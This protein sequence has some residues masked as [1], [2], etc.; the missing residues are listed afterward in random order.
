M[1]ETFRE[2]VSASA[3]HGTYTDL[4]V[5][6]DRAVRAVADV[7]HTEAPDVTIGVSWGTRI[8]EMRDTAELVPTL[9]EASGT[10]QRIRLS[11]RN[12][13]AGAAVTLT[14]TPTTPVIEGVVYGPSRGP[15]ESVA[16]QL[17]GEIA[18]HGR[19]YGWGSLGSVLLAVALLAIV[20][21]IASALMADASGDAANRMAFVLFCTSVLALVLAW[22][23]PLSGS[24]LNPPLQ[25]RS[26]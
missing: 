15:V 12:P 2:A 21:A 24:R 23:L 14:V 9:R 26:D 10:V 22:A 7:A 19:W 18:R 20:G 16:A 8:V 5:L 11:A 4:Q 3:W 17:R 13:A 1:A 6:L 25:L